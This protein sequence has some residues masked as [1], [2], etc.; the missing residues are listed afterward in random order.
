MGQAL[1]SAAWMRLG[2]EAINALIL[3]GFECHLR[4]MTQLSVCTPEITCE[5]PLYIT[6]GSVTVYCT[7][8][9]VEENLFIKY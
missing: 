3:E 9:H 1:I 2:I 8:V 5:T 6:K 4:M 7:H